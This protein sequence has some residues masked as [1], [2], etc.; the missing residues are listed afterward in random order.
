MHTDATG[1]ILALERGALD[2]WGN[3]D[4]TGYLAISA[5]DVSYFDPLCARRIDGH[6]TL[7]EYYRP[8]AG[9]IRIEKDE[10][11][12]PRV[13]I[14][15]EVAILSFQYVSHGSEGAMRW[16]CTEVYAHRGEA[17]RIVHTHWSFMAAASVDPATRAGESR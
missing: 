6:P 11:I 7:T 8:I 9:M 12:A 2:R 10:I 15:G 3:G 1:L 13:Q 16:N 5:E 17:W 14:Y 4:P